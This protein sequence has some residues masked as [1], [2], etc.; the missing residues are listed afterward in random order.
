MANQI[1]IKHG[2]KT[3]LPVLSNSELGFVTDE[4][5][6]YIGTG[7]ANIRILTEDDIYT[8]SDVDIH[9]SGGT[10]INYSTG[11]ISTNDSEID[12]NSL[13]N[14]SIDEHRTIDDTASGSTDLFSAQKITND[15]KK[16]SGFENRTDSS[17]GMNSNN[18][19]ITTASSYN[20]YIK[21]IGKKTVSSTLSIEITEDQ[22]ITYVY[23]D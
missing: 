7:S 20:V 13:S 8:D 14:Y 22:N 6:L 16:Y 9:L 15:Y 18:F 1:I 5:E 3:N 11:V 19:E 23:L 10:G 17:I 2:I 21:N 12:H 4:Q